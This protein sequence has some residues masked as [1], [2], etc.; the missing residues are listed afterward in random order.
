[1]RYSWNVQS[2]VWS[3]KWWNFQFVRVK[4][5]HGVN[6]CKIDKVQ[7]ERDLPLL[8]AKYKLAPSTV[9]PTSKYLAENTQFTASYAPLSSSWEYQ[10]CFLENLDFLFV[11]F[12]WKGR[13][14]PMYSQ[15][16]LCFSLFLCWPPSPEKHQLAK[17]HGKEGEQERLGMWIVVCSENSEISS[18]K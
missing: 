8:G 12:L 16:R 3:F 6:K 17:I 5:F 11:I 10:T 13:K 15:S 9:I 7:R 18:I 4:I 2:N 14:T 1:M